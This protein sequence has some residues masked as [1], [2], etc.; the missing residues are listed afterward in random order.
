[1][2][3]GCLVGWFASFHANFCFQPGSSSNLNL[4]LC[5]SFHTLDIFLRKLKAN[6]ADIKS[7]GS[8]AYQPQ[9]HPQRH[10]PTAQAG[11]LHGIFTMFDSSSTG[12]TSS[13]GSS[14]SAEGVAH[15]QH[16]PY[17]P[18]PEPHPYPL[19]PEKLLDEVLHV[20]KEFCWLAGGG[21][22]VGLLFGYLTW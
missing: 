11:W 17:S 10:Q 19:L 14:G 13:T 7:S 3:I 18:P 20:V 6:E 15:P 12:S 1:M 16:H 9:P 2:L 5:S 21:L 22:L 4:F 8:S